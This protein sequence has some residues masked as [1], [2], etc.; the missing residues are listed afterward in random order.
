MSNG[1]RIFMSPATAPTAL[2]IG[3]I[4]SMVVVDALA[5]AHT[6]AGGHGLRAEAWSL[7]GRKF[8]ALYATSGLSEDEFIQQAIQSG[9]ASTESWEIAP[10]P[11]PTL[12]HDEPRVSAAL[13]TQV[14]ELAEQGRIQLLARPQH[15]C[16]RC[17]LTMPLTKHE[18]CFQ[19]GGQI[20][21][22]NTPAWYLHIDR[23]AI[24]E[25]IDEWQ[26]SSTSARSR[27]LA[28]RDGYEWLRISQAGLTVGPT[29]PLD[30]NERLDARVVAAGHPL[31]L[32]Q[33]GIDAPITLVSGVDILRKLHLTLWAMTTGR[34]PIDRVFAHGLILTHGR[35]VSRRAGAQRPTVTDPI[36]IA[37][38][39]WALLGAPEAR[40]T[41]QAALR[42]AEARRLI[43]KLS[44]VDNYLRRHRPPGVIDV[45][46][47]MGEH[48]LRVDEELQNGAPNRIVAALSALVMHA[49]R[50]VIPRCQAN[51]GYN[52]FG[53][54]NAMAS[55]TEVLT[56][57]TLEKIGQRLVP[58]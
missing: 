15:R 42:I 34:S 43:I 7:A 50:D 3:T 29:S 24:M 58:A 10:T 12:R 39:R 32:S 23:R 8:E 20:L 40:D 47:M 16:S 22:D 57:A 51:G 9:R 14:S 11:L 41:D 6:A 53:V 18:T 48:V 37:A 46:T 56:G 5:R 17:D 30:P 1:T 19:C 25:R 54:L 55:A 21:A 4:R 35:K 28:L 49:S 38:M 36:E 13:R 27:F 26:W 33:L 44:H 52:S 31:A 2:H 45:G